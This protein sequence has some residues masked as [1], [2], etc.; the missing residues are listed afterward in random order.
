MIKVMF[1]S[2]LNLGM[3]LGKQTFVEVFW[4]SYIRIGSARGGQ[5]LLRVD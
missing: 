1:R 2:K 4:G 3:E 5:V